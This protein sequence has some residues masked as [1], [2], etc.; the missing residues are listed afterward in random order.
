MMARAATEIQPGNVGAILHATE[1][2]QK[3]LMG[4]FERRMGLHVAF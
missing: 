4:K 3:K 2:T 1:K